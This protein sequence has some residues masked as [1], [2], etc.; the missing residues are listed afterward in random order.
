[1]HNVSLQLQLLITDSN[2]VHDFLF[3]FLR[4]IQSNLGFLAM[5]SVFLFDIFF[6]NFVT[7]NVRLLATNFTKF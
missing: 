5:F 1:M 2:T 7:E 3:H 6:S 4:C